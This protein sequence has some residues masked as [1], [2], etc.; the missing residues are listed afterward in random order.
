MVLLPK[1][2]ALVGAMDTHNVS[3][4]HYEN[5]CSFDRRD[6]SK[7]QCK[8]SGLAHRPVF[9]EQRAFTQRKEY[10]KFTR[11]TIAP[12]KPQPA[13]RGPP[14]LTNQGWR[15]GSCQQIIC[16]PV[17]RTHVLSQGPGCNNEPKKI[18]QRRGK[19]DRH[20]E[21]R[22]GPAP[23]GSGSLRIGDQL[24]V[25]RGVARRSSRL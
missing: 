3:S 8:L 14:G 20:G 16:K 5:L 2:N 10:T 21:S 19:P 12:I 17:L 11:L 1:W 23:D 7:P 25:R 24:P 9:S 13:S 4:L 22:L 15:R 18:R 6:L